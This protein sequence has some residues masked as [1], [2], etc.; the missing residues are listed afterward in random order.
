MNHSKS[1]YPNN[2][3]DRWWD[4]QRRLWGEDAPLKEQA[5]QDIFDILAC[6]FGPL[7]TR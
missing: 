4:E 6:A 7:K 2:H 5:V 3:F 1:S